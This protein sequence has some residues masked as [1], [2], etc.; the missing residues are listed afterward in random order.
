MADLND[1]RLDL[2]PSPARFIAFGVAAAILMVALGGRL[3][4][5]QVVN[6]DEYARRASADR[7]IAVPLPAPRGLIFDRTGR[8]LAVN[9]PS[10]TVK[11]RPA[12]LPDGEASRILARLARVTGAELSVLRD[13]LE[14]YRGSP[15]DL[16]PVERG[17][18]REAAL[19][20]GEEAEELPGIVVE[21][22]AVRRY[23]DEEGEASGPLLSHVVGYTGPVNSDEFPRLEPKGYLR[24]DVIGR[25][26]IEASFEES[27]AASM[28]PSASTVTRPGALRR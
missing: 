2:H 20:L 3:F 5:L 4:Q 9:T 1:G 24:D 7:T 23:L 28:G 17:I 8:P 22:E 12:D 16:V 27:C 18:S 10:W 26:G 11:V 19:V 21:V 15:F 13:R 6:G 14:A 25:D